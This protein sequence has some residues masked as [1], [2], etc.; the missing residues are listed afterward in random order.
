VKADGSG[1]FSLPEE[2]DTAAAVLVMHENGVREMSLAE[3]KQG[4]DG[5]MVDEAKSGD[6]KS[7]AAL[8]RLQPWGRIE[9]KVQWGDKAGAD[10]KVS[11]SIFRDRYGY[12]GVIAQYEKTKSLAD[13]SFTFD[14]VLPGLTQ[15]SCPIPAG[16][17]GSGI[18]EI[19]LTGQTTHVTVKP[20]VTPAIIGG[21]GRTV[22]GR[23][24]GRDS[25]E[26][27]TFHFHPTAP[28]IGMPGDD[29]MWK[30]WAE[31]QKSPSGPLFFR[32]GL[33]VNADGSFEI[34]NVLPGDYQI[35]FTRQGE[36]A[37][38]AS[39]KVSVEAESP[40]IKPEA[41]VLPDLKA[42]P[43]PGPNDP[44]KKKTGRASGDGI[45]VLKDIPLIDRLFQLPGQENKIPAIR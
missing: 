34:P 36:P 32:D 11:L 30:A 42:T 22:K 19:N 43:A 35:F 25:W 28:H 39:S 12:P 9:G 3:F 1:S 37:H 24:E 16:A 44:D 13:G 26:G 18:T 29:A 41:Q 20:G 27:V 40:G 38:V 10:Q 23:L 8:V 17:N 45:P 6:E 2:S 14:H 31:F 4:P 5:F 7:K 15:L 21:Q 33:K